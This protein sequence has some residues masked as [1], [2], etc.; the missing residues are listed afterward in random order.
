MVAW[1]EEVKNHVQGRLAVFH[2]QR[3]LA[4]YDADGQLQKTELQAVA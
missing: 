1:T 4:R 2:G 3:C